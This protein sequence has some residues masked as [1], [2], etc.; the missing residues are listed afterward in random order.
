MATTI[1]YLSKTGLSRYDE[2]IKAFIAAA[3]K[4]D[5]DELQ[6]LITAAN[7]AITA[8]ETAR[9]AAD[10]TLTT[11]VQEAA[12][13]ASAAQKTADD[14]TTYVGTFTASEGVDTVVKYI[15]AKTANI[16]SDETVGAI[17]Q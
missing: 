8:E 11:E 3:D 2:K 9:K 15:D 16:A 13:A 17:T 7:E 1:E 4:A 6:A 5:K 10:L 12:D 14:I